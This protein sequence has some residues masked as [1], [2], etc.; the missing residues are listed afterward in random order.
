MNL[1]ARLARLEKASAS[2][3]CAACALC[4]ASGKICITATIAEPGETS[5]PRPG[6][7]RCG[8][9]GVYVVEFERPGARSELEA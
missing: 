4:G 7:P 1:P 6:C 2:R 9:G 5:G 8:D 3:G